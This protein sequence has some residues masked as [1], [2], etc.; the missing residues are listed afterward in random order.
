[1]KSIKDCYKDTK[2]RAASL[3][4]RA[5]GYRQHEKNKKVKNSKPLNRDVTET[6]GVWDQLLSLIKKGKACCEYGEMHSKMSK[7]MSRKQREDSR[8]QQHKQK[9]QSDLYKKIDEGNVNG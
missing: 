3:I 9:Q 2:I 1:M 7:D 5:N 6:C 8:I 4:R